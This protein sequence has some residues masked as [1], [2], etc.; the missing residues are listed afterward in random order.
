MY[1]RSGSCD[2]PELG[3]N[4]DT[5]GCTTGE[6][7]DYHGSRLAPF[8]TAGQTYFIV[9]DGYNGAEGSFGLTIVPPTPPA[10]GTCAAPLPIPP[11]GGVV[12]GTTNGA[13]A[14]GACAASNGSPEK[15]YRWTPTTSGT[16]V[17]E[18]CGAQ[19][20]YDTVV[21]V[22][23]GACGAPV[24]ACVDDAVGCTTSSGN[25]R[26]SRLTPTVTAGQT[27]Y[28]VVDGYD[29]TAGSFRLSVTPP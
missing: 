14:V 7:H 12:T 4:D 11:E 9:V 24:L 25:D 27:Y 21:Y 28:V 13:S 19:T 29:G 22:S 18:T 16:A 5:P 8:V 6:P 20:N 17:I 1:V 26:G 10:D 2:G 3:C 15:V 23:E